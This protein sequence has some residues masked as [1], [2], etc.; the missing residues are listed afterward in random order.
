MKTALI[1]MHIALLVES[2]EINQNKTHYNYQQGIGRIV[3]SYHYLLFNIDVTT[4]LKTFKHITAS[5]VILSKHGELKES[6]LLKEAE[7]LC[8]EI[9]Q[10]LQIIMPSNMRT[11]RGLINGLSTAIKYI[12]GNP[13]ANNLEKINNYLNS[14]QHQQQENVF[15]LNKSLSVI[16][17]ISAQINNNTNIINENL[18]DMWKTVNDQT[19]QSNLFQAVMILITQEQHFLGLLNKIKRSFIFNEQLFDLEI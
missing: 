14:L 13:D 19:L 12:F 10:N 5:Y 18:K 11:K 7:I 6:S 1:L 15:T 16:N 9:H 8:N 17:T 4:L 2:S 3:G